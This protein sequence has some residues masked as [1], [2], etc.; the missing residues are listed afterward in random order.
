MGKYQKCGNSHLDLRS[1]IMT[2]DGCI[3]IIS[4][5]DGHTPGGVNKRKRSSFTQLFLIQPYQSLTSNA[6]TIHPR[7]WFSLS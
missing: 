3:S 2:K 7:A 1:G 4:D 6:F 5:S